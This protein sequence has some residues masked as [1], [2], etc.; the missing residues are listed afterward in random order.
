MADTIEQYVEALRLAREHIS[1]LHMRHEAAERSW[2]QTATRLEQRIAWLE[3][4]IT[5]SV[6]QLSRKTRV[7]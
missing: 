7:T 5:G 4:Q 2:M 6:L 3:G 1:E